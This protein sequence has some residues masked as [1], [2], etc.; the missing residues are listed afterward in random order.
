[1][2]GRPSV[3]IIIP[4]YNEEAVIRQ[5]VEAAIYQTV[6]AH[7]IIVVDNRSTDSTAKIVQQVAHEFPESPIRLLRQDEHQGL[8]PTR[9]FGLGSATGQVLGRIDADSLIEPTWVERVAETFADPAVD[10]ATGP[11]LYYDM[12]LR[13]FGLK[14][15]DRIRQ[16]VLKVAYRQYHFLFG[17]NMA[18]RASAWEKVADE[19]CRDEEDQ[20][21]E[22]I[23]ISVHMAQHD[24]LIRYVPDMIAGMS[25]RRLEDSPKDYRY[26]VTRFDRT[27][28]A[29]Q[30]NRPLLKIPPLIFMAIYYPA[31]ALR[32]LHA[33]LTRTV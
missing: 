14:A 16:L 12:P 26:Y 23:D 10:G 32:Y 4:A 19:V 31:K 24:M 7:E 9:D 2:T 25:A 22:D 1:M 6:P 11:V 5:C 13:R 20:M 30:I 21:H 3:S 33:G 28:R 15:D 18:L 29:H 27:Y 8:I 17:S